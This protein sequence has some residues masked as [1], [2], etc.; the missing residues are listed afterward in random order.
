MFIYQFE[1]VHSMFEGDRISYLLKI[2]S[3]LTLMSFE[4]SCIKIFPYIDLLHDQ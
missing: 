1:I 4:V 3:H 2:V